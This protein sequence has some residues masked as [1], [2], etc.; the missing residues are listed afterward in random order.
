MKKILFLIVAL[1]SMLTCLFYTFDSSFFK[2]MEIESK[3]IEEQKSKIIYDANYDFSKPLT[4]TF[5]N[6]ALEEQREIKELHTLF[7]TSNNNNFILE[8]YE[9]SPTFFSFNLLHYSDTLEIN[10]DTRDCAGIYEYENISQ[11][12]ILDRKNKIVGDS[13]N[14]ALDMIFVRYEEEDEFRDTL[15]VKGCIKTKIED[16]D[17]S[18]REKLKEFELNQ[19]RKLHK[20]NPDT[21]INI[22]LGSFNLS[23]ANLINLHFQAAIR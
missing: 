7:R 11:K 20:Q 16:F 2:K 19:L 12:I 6:G 22:Y 8:F 13:I 14:I 23:N 21:V 17:Y 1:A 10:A 9:D 3:K 5:K 18:R 15:F 4:L